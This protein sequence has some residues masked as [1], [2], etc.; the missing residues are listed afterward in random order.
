MT[1]ETTHK[2]AAYR[3]RIPTWDGAPCNPVVECYGID[4]FYG[5]AA[6]PQG[7]DECERAIAAHR[8]LVLQEAGPRYDS[9]LLDLLEETREYIFHAAVFEREIGEVPD[10]EEIAGPGLVD[11]LDSWISEIKSHQQPAREGSNE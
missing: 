10:D 8:A 3:I 2:P 5:P 4:H 6:P 11:R 7:R 9:R 1:D